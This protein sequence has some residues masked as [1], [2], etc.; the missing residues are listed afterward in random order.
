MLASGG[1]FVAWRA[2]PNNKSTFDARE[3]STMLQKWTNCI[4]IIAI[5][6]FISPIF[7][8]PARAANCGGNIPCACGDNVVANRTLVS[9]VDPILGSVCGVDGLFM[10]IP[11]VVL[12]L[13][14]KI[15]RG[16]GNGVGVLIG[17]DNV[18]IEDGEIHTFGTG[19]STA[20][21]TS[22]STIN[23][24]KPNANQGDGIF[25]EGDNNELIAIRAKHNGNNGVRVIGNNNR[26]EG[27]NDEYS[28]FHGILVEGDGNE[29]VANLASENRKKGPANG[30]TVIGNN[31][32]LELN[33][34]T[35][36]NTNGIYVL[37]NDNVLS[38][39][40]A[41]KQDKDG[42]IVGGADN[43]LTDNQATKNKGVGI[44]V[45]G[46]GNPSASQGNVVKKNSKK[47]PC[48][49]YGVTAPP[50]CI[51]K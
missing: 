46:S 45:V 40:E 35:K 24:I 21:T 42:I 2:D 11:G 16:S 33:R 13:N 3:E 49:I 34:M 4:L 5:A 36:M 30:I 12:D 8:S 29:L 28:G 31:N 20:S 44:I 9:G 39:N 48:S 41:T 18:T 37:G 50:V 1:M 19:I 14:G 51:A 27:H 10:N 25:I 43:V 47:P 26:L 6:I 15:I 23:G 7:N 17:A 32:T 38:R 22:G